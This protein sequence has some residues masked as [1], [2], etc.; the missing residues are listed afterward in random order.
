MLTQ[1]INLL[2]AAVGR[3]Q[4]FE[5]LIQAKDI[6]RVIGKMESHRERSEEA[7]L[8]YDPSKHKINERADKR[9]LDKNG[10]LKRTIKRWKLPIDYCKFINEIA[11]VFIYGQPVKWGQTSTDTDEAFDAVTNLL[12]DV[13]F[14]SKI[15]QCKRYAGAETQSAMLFRVFKNKH[16]NPDCQVRVLAFSKGDEIFTRWDEYENLLSFG[17]GHY[18]TDGDDTRYHFDLYTDETIY[19]CVR[20]GKGWK[21]TEE[22]NLIGKI[23]VIYFEQEKEWDGVFPLIEREEYIA[24]RSADVNDYFS[25]PMLILDA[26][27]IKNLPERDD[28]NKTLIKTSGADT[29]AAAGYL[30]WDSASASKEAEKEW[31]QKQILTKTFTPNIDFDTM[32]QLSNVSGKALKQ[33]MILANIK[34]SKRKETHDEM[35]DRVAGLCTS[36]VGNVLNVSLRNQCDKLI[37]THEFQDPFGEDVADVINNITKAKDGGF[38]STESAVELSPTTKNVKTE[39]ERL[40]EDRESAEAA[41]RDLFTQTALAATGVSEGTDEGLAD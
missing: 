40:A 32:R 39:M 23:P 38:L 26:D 22:D 10:N 27:I 20:G 34:A 19:H 30:T 11:L 2:N 7:L 41:Q 15:K 17:W 12:K 33:M 21:M 16:G 35:M 14:D 4:E 6:D 18:V 3:K 24:S 13:H 36:I 37:I 1:I 9:V 5:E 28:E 29:H 8:E 31:L 25:D